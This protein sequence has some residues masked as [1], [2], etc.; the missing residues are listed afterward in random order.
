MFLTSVSQS[1][2]HLQWIMNCKEDVAKHG[3]CCS[4]P[5]EGVAPRWTWRSPRVVHNSLVP[6]LAI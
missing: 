6:N 1:S 2:L 4:T 3:S 5:K